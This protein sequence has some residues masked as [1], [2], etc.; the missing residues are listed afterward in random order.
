MNKIIVID[1]PSG[2]PLISLDDI[3]ESQGDLKLPPEPDKLERLMRSILDHHVFIAKAIFYEDGVPYTED[4]HQT[5]AALRAMRN[6]GYRTCQVVKYELVDGNMQETGRE[7][8][9]HIVVPC[10]IIVP[11][12]A[13]KDERRR[14]AAKKLLQINSRYAEINPAT[15]WFNDLGFDYD[16]FD[17]L[18]SQISL[19]EIEQSFSAVLST[20]D[21]VEPGDDEEFVKEFESYTNEN[22]LFP[23]VP[24]FSEKHCSVIIVIENETELAGVKTALQLGREKSYKNN[25]V[26]ETFV[27]SA[28]R[29][30]SLWQARL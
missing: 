5:L 22:A 3:V 8:F 29:F 1:N 14:D 27:I 7:N 30:A 24:R 16:E 18:V 25:T 6:N 4:G 15:T 28:E 2:L 10:Q 11:A 9:D 21:T 20:M 26:G 12:G 17:E 23:L 19:P 13:T